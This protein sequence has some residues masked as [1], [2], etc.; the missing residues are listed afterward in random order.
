[1]TAPSQPPPPRC[2]ILFVLLMAVPSIVSKAINAPV[3][4]YAYGGKAVRSGGGAIRRGGRAVAEAITGGQDSGPLDTLSSAKSALPPAPSALSAME[5]AVP[6]G[7]QQVAAAAPAAEEK[8]QAGAAAAAAAAAADAAGKVAQ[9]AA[10]PLGGK[11][12]KQVV[13]PD[14]GGTSSTTVVW[15]VWAFALY[16]AAVALLA[17]GTVRGWVGWCWLAASCWQAGRQAGRQAGAQ[18]G[19]LPARL[20]QRS[21]TRRNRLGSVRCPGAVL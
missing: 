13:V 19:R 7:E 1:M 21:D 10:P 12:S 16:I 2:S 8:G 5:E 11:P 14:T 9:Q 20:Q 17:I 6:A 15:L 18:P 4:L 3:L